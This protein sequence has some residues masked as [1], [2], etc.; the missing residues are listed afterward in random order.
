[1]ADLPPTCTYDW[2]GLRGEKWAATAVP[3]EAML[4]PLTPVLSAALPAR[5]VGTVVDVGCGAGA[6]TAALRA[7]F[8]D[9]DVT[10][11]DIA[12]PLVALAR[13]RVPGVRFVQ[14]D[15]TTA[16]PHPCDLLVSRLGV[17]F[18]EEPVVGFR[19]LRDWLVPG[20]RFVF[21]VWGP[22]AE[23]PWA[24]TVREAV[25][26]ASPPPPRDPG[27]PR[28]PGPF[29]HGEPAAFEAILSAAGFVELAHDKW[30]GDLALGGGLPP[31]E[32]AAF[33]LDAFSNFAERLHAAGPAARHCAQRA[34][35]TT[36]AAHTQR[37]GAIE[38]RLGACVHVWT[39]RRPPTEHEEAP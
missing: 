18:F 23:N 19:A 8:P 7:S 11:V 35:H 33:A 27:A 15:V 28:P 5:G 1:M 37:R 31:A 20:G 21:A 14:A 16:V 3:M 29:R 39:G 13:E 10:G 26:A 30:R 2:P 36:F 38:V 25:D 9:A 6:S 32:A 22:A 17:M 4:A 24:T 12:A 34:L